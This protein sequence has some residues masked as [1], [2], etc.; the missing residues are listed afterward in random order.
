MVP[1]TAETAAKE[2]LDDLRVHDREVLEFLSQDPMT[3]VA[4]Q[5]IRRRLGM[6]PEKL[7]RALHRLADDSLVEKTDV[8]YRI[9]RKA[10]SILSPRDWTPEPPGMTVL[11][12]YIPASL[13]LRG[14]VTT[15]RGSW[16]G[17][18]RWYGLSESPEGLRLSWTLEDESI[19]VETRIGAGELSIVAHVASPDRLD[20]A[21]RL[22]H[23]LFREIAT[24][25]SRDRYPG[26]V[27]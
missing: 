14:L 9:T 3:H 22:G 23:L 19:R 5:G 26:L 27:A 13:D 24:E 20:E 21:A 1:T 6:H 7:S 4:F 12:T 16:V 25:I 18:L 2:H 10:W 8:G 11:Q 17:P 15:L